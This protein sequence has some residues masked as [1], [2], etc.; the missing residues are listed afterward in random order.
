MTYELSQRVRRE[1]LMAFVVI[2]P[3]VLNAEDEGEQAGVSYYSNS[4]TYDDVYDWFRGPLNA[5]VHQL[6]FGAVNLDPKVVDLAMPRAL[7]QSR[8]GG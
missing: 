2:G 6:R 4:P 5:R 8:F 7:S 3:A 1:E